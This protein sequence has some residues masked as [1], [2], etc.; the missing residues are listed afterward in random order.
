MSFL[1]NWRTTL[2]GICTIL[3]AIGNFGRAALDNDDKTQPNVVET[4]ALIMGGAGL[5]AAGDA[6]KKAE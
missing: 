2:F 3:F 1:N 4:G 6:K 5:I